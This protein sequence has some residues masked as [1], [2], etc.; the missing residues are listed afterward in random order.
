MRIGAISSLNSSVGLETFIDVLGED[1]EFEQLT[2]DQAKTDIDVSGYDLFFLHNTLNV[3]AEVLEK[4]IV[5]ALQTVTDQ[6]V[7]DPDIQKR[8][9]SS[10][11]LEIW[12]NTASAVEDLSSVGISSKVFYRPMSNFKTPTTYIPLPQKNAI[13]WYYKPDHPPMKPQLHEISNL[14]N[15]IEGTTVYLFPAVE[16][17]IDKE[18][19]KAVGRVDLEEWIPKVRGMVRISDRLDFGRSTFDILGHGRWVLYLNMR[20]DD[21]FSASSISEIPAMISHLLES[22]DDQRCMARFKRSKR[23][24]KTAL[25]ETWSKQIKQVVCQKK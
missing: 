2:I 21:V 5:Y 14:L 17:P 15:Q 7:H 25:R 10:C 4:S 13:L 9:K 12:C 19:I 8:I 23:L 22:E 24:D 18:N 3:T 20:E 1:F 16:S 6:I 11:P